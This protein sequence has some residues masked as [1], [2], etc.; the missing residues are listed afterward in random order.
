MS[1]GRKSLTSVYM[2]SGLLEIAKAEFGARHS[3]NRGDL[4]AEFLGQ[5]AVKQSETSRN[6]ALGFPRK[7]LEELWVGKD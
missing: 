2:I 6:S 4:G 5:W 3:A 1:L 7:A